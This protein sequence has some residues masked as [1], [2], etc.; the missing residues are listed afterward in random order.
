MQSKVIA[1]QEGLHEASKLLKEKGYKVT[2][3][4]KAN[5]AIDVIV[6]S[7]SNKEYL[8]HNME[9]SLGIPSYNQFVRM[10]NLDEVGIENLIA[11]VEDIE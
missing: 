9:G 5:E 4:D 2:T 11:T 8:A 3:V 10:I 7:N 1:V 6:Y